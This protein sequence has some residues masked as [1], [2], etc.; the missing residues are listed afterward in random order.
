MPGLPPSE[1]LHETR[2]GAKSNAASSK[3]RSRFGTST[4]LPRADAIGNRD[5]RGP[6]S[7]NAHW[8]FMS[9]S[10]DSRH[11]N[12]PGEYVRRK[13]PVSAIAWAVQIA[14]KR[15]QLWLA[16]TL[17]ENL[18]EPLLFG[19]ARRHQVGW[20]FGLSKLGI[21]TCHEFARLESSKTSSATSCPLRQ[22]FSSQRSIVSGTSRRRYVRK[23]WRLR[24]VSVRKHKQ[25][26]LGRHGQTRT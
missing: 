17:Q 6:C 3:T 1:R 18:N 26:P 22:R 21:R 4:G 19:V 13:V 14:D 15:L 24:T 23:C 25:P 9:S 10:S 20:Q 12:A 8:T 7:M 5:F 2:V 16:R 11:S